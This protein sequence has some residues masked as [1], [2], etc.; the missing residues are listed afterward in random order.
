MRKYFELS[1][2]QGLY[3]LLS[4]ASFEGIDSVLELLF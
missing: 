3:L 4:Q 2:L 1:S